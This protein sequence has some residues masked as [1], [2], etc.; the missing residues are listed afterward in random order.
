MVVYDKAKVLARTEIVAE[1]DQWHI[2]DFCLVTV[3]KLIIKDGAHINAGAKILG[4]ETVE[5]G[6]RSVISYDVLVLTSTDSPN[7]YEWKHNDYSPESER[8][9]Q[10]Q[11]ITIGDDCF[12]GAKSVLMPGVTLL[13]KQVVP[14]GSYVYMKE[15]VPRCR[16]LGHRAR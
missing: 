12:I 7:P 8:R 2:G 11:C 16:P 3:P 4:R 15:G 13:D 9:I 1:T 6:K 5:L 14:A 10:S